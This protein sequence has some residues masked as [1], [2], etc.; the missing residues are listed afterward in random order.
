M[1]PGPSSPISY[2]NQVAYYDPGL[3]AGEIE[4]VTPSKI[5]RFL[6]SAFGAGIEGNM[7]DCYAKIISYFEPGDRIILIGFSRAP[8]VFGPWQT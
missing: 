1:R 4:G 3:G 8:I 6:E 7:I 2:L 5:K